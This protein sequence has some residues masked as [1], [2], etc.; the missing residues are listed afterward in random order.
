MAI[1]KAPKFKQGD[2]VRFTSEVVT[3]IGISSRIQQGH[4]LKVTE[5]PSVETF[6]GAYILNT[7]D[8]R[9]AC[10]GGCIAREWDIELVPSDNLIDPLAQLEARI[11]EMR[12]M[13]EA[14]R[15]QFNLYAEQHEAKGTPDSQLKARTNRA[16]AARITAVLRGR[17]S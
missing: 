8:E 6:A 17:K 14:C 7:F 10:T 2:I 4:T 3:P 5:E 13:L 12:W 1:T 9:G 11:D 15:D 16:I